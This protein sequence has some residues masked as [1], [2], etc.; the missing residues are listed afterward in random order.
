MSIILEPTKIAN[1]NSHVLLK[2]SSSIL[3]DSFNLNN[4]YYYKISASGKFFLFDDN[5]DV[6]DSLEAQKFIFKHRYYCHPRYHQ[7]CFRIEKTFENPFLIGLETTK[8]C[9]LQ[10]EFNLAID[11][12]HKTDDFVEGFGFHSPQSDEKQ[13]RFLSNHI[14]ELR[15]FAKWFLEKNTRANAFLKENSLDLSCLLGP[16]FYKNRIA[17]FD[18]SLQVR[19]KFLKTLGIVHDFQL[20][21]LEL[22]TL[23]FILQGYSA[24]QIA[25]NTHRSKRTIEHRLENIKSKLCVSSK[26]ELIQKTQK[27]EH[28]GYLIPCV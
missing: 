9:F 5:L 8:S 25:K 10:S 18:P 15:L 27:L 24:S 21:Q 22:D 19:Q 28:S 13:C 6:I 7:S 23:R 20:S 11:F 16:D 26:T 4:F 14:A 3:K 12:I 2:K 1:K 17:E